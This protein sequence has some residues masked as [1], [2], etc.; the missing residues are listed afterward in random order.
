M[1]RKSLKLRKTD[2][3]VILIVMAVVYIIGNIVMVLATESDEK[4]IEAGTALAMASFIVYELMTSIGGSY[5]RWFN[6]EVSMGN[7]R[8]GF[9]VSQFIISVV[10]VALEYALLVILHFVNIAIINKLYPGQELAFSFDI[11]LFSIYVPVVCLIFITFQMLAGSAW[12]KEKK[13]MLVFTWIIWMGIC[14]LPGRIS[15]AVKD[16]KN[17]A[18]AN[19]GHFFI[20]IFQNTNKI[21]IVLAGLALSLIMYAAAYLMTRKQE[22][23]N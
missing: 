20:N 12:L 11:I 5:K 19:V 17:T 3:Y 6:I 15:D 8:K 4:V 1:I 14:I 9:F 13:I 23:E 22:V 21:V 7:T 2:I 16:D 10:R 18:L